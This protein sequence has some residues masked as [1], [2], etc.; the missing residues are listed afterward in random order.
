M[1]QGTV[2]EEFCPPLEPPVGVPVREGSRT[3]V[4]ILW[5]GETVAADDGGGN[6]EANDRGT[7]A[8]GE[9]EI[10]AFGLACSD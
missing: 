9:V 7:G 1:V 6:G 10:V 3:G 4:I 2:P 8:I 5:I